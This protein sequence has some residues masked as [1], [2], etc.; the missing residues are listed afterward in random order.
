MGNVS[1]NNIARLARLRDRI[2]V[3]RMVT[4][5][6]RLGVEDRSE[7]RRMHVTSGIGSAARRF[8]GGDAMDP[9]AGVD[10]E[11]PV[12]FLFLRSKVACGIGHR[13]DLWL[14]DFIGMPMGHD[15]PR[16]AGED[17]L[18]PIGAFAVREGDQKAVV[19]LNRYDRGLVTPT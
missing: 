4:V 9:E 7:H 2:P 8:C 6:L 5:R 12:Q 1:L 3:Y 19:V 11:A 13:D 16:P 15:G 14:I 10:S 17:V 18:H